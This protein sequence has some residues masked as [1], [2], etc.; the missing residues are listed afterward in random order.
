MCL[1]GLGVVAAL[2]LIAFWALLGKY[3]LLRGELDDTRMT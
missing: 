1:I 2:S 3:V